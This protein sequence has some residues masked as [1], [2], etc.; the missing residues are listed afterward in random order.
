[1]GVQ[2]FFESCNKRSI[3]KTIQYTYV[4]ELS[5]Q[6]IYNLGFGDYDSVTDS[7]SDDVTTNNEDHFRVLHTVLSSI[8]CFFKVFSKAMIMIQGS[9]SK[10]DFIEKCK[11]SCKKRCF[12]SECKNYHR[13]IRLY[14]HYLNKNYAELEKDFI[15]YG[16]FKKDGQIVTEFY[17]KNKNYDSVFFI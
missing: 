7:F 12:N 4:Q 13:R 2:Y 14:Q 10:P 1:M 9:D 8:P 17:V 5:G 6:S 3:L 15:F 11:L 16:G